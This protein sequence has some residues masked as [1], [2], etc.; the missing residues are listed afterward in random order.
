[1]TFVD[2]RK[3]PPTKAGLYVWRMDHRYIPS[4]T[5]VFVASMRL[6]GAGHENVLSPEFDYWD[7]YKLILPS[8]PI[9]W[10]EWDGEEPS[11]GREILRIEGLNNDSCPFCHAVPKWAYHSP[12]VSQTPIRAEK[13][14]LECCGWAAN[15]YST[16][17]RELT[18]LRNAALRKKVTK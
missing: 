13:F 5:I 8:G 16:D 11:Y 3:L 10:A 12:E 1:M 15:T 18:K 7:G 9:E 6:R 17:P 4:L 14:H 2:Y